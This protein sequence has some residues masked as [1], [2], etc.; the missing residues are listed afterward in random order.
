MQGKTEKRRRVVFPSVDPF[1]LFRHNSKRKKG[2][3]MLLISLLLTSSICIDFLCQF[4]LKFLIMAQPPAFFGLQLQPP[5]SIA[6]CL[7]L[8]S[9][10]LT[11]FY[12]T[13]VPW[14]TALSHIHESMPVWVV[15]TGAG[16]IPEC[17][18]WQEN[19]FLIASEK[20]NEDSLD[21]LSCL[22]IVCCLRV[23]RS[24]GTNL[25]DPNSKY[26]FSQREDSIRI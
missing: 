26:K 14:L 2:K 1:L 16:E 12:G 11:P 24:K 17:A 13:L 23:S 10:F 20:Q 21:T 6:H 9:H 15:G 25:E 19:V 7:L 22:M 5:G 4:L 8:H 18:V 3:Q